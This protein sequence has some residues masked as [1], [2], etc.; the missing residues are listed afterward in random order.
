[1]KPV[2]YIQHEEG[3]YNTFSLNTWWLL[4]FQEDWDFLQLQVALL[5]NSE[6]SGIPIHMQVGSYCRCWWL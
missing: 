1:M 2:H 4:L 3:S 5:Y 6:T